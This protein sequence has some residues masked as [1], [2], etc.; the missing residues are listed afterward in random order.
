[1]ENVT[2][3]LIVLVLLNFC[4]ASAS[5]AAD[6]VGKIL[7]ASGEATVIRSNGT[8]EAL[9]RHDLIY[10]REVLKTGAGLLQIKFNDGGFMSLQKHSEMRVEDYRFKGSEDGSE[11]AIFSLIKGGLRAIS[12]AIGHARPSRYQLRTSVA[13]IGI[14]G[15]AYSAL[16]CNQDCG[17]INGR[18]LENGL[19]AKTTEGTIFVQNDA[20]IVDVSVGQ[21][22]FV[23]D[24]ATI[25]VYTEFNPSFSA[26]TPRFENKVALSR[27]ENARPAKSVTDAIAKSDRLS[28]VRDLAAQTTAIKRANFDRFVAPADNFTNAQ[29]NNGVVGN[30]L[31]PQLINNVAERSSQIANIQKASPSP[32]INV[33]RTQ[34]LGSVTSSGLDAATIAPSVSESVSNVLA[35]TNNLSLETRVNEINTPLQQLNTNLSVPS[36]S[37]LNPL[38]P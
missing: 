9:K 36:G 18:E 14:R 38:H 28:P 29:L 23:P 24:I 11:S 17:E 7:F 15:T 19:H 27:K 16:L 20:G 21:A 33:V 30:A 22:A 6:H 2:K 1:M 4:F 32:N 8:Q 35:N 5:I 37:L 26:I 3:K 12:G 13:T 25:P 34:A 31:E 10:N